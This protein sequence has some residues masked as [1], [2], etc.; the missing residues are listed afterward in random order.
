MAKNVERVCKNCK[1][2]NPVEEV[3]SVA[4]V[5]EGERYELPVKP[6]DSCHWERL[7]REVNK[8]IDREIRFLDKESKIYFKEKLE[9][10]KEVPIEIKQMR[11][12]SDGKDG[13]IEY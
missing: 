4:I 6:N 5:Y 7:D 9:G 10:E 11:A 1:L 13:F 12:W 3:C 8:D 2:Y